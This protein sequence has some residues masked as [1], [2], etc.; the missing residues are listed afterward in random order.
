MFHAGADARPPVQ[1]HV[2]PTDLYF[3]VVVST[4]IRIVPT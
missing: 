4:N 2:P 1:G 3:L